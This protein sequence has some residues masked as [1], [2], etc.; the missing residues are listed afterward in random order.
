MSLHQQKIGFWMILLC[1]MTSTLHAEIVISDV[2]GSSDGCNGSFHLLVN[3]NAG[4]FTIEVESG[5]VLYPLPSGTPQPVTEFDGVI[6]DLCE[7]FYSVMVE[8]SKGCINYYYVDVEHCDFEFEFNIR[9]PTTC[10]SENGRI[11]VG[12]GSNGPTILEGATT[13]LHIEWSNGVV[14][15]GASGLTGISNLGPGEYSVTVTDATGCSDIGTISLYAEDGIELE[16]FYLAGSCEGD[17]NGIAEVIASSSGSPLDFTYN[18]T[19]SETG[20]IAESLWPGWSCVTVTDNVSDCEAVACIEIETIQP[21]PEPFAPSFTEVPYCYSDENPLGELIYHPQGGTPPFEWEWEW[22][23]PGIVGYLGSGSQNYLPEGIYNVTITDHCGEVFEDSYKIIKTNLDLNA[24]VVNE[25]SSDDPDE[26]TGSITL[27]PDA[28]P[29][30]FGPF[31]YE[32]YWPWQGSHPYEFPTDNSNELTGLFNDTGPNW[33]VTVTDGIGCTRV[34]N[35][36]I[37]VDDVE[38][39]VKKGHYDGTW[40][41]PIGGGN[42]GIL[43]ADACQLRQFCGSN[44]VEGGETSSTPLG[45]YRDQSGCWS[46]VNCE[47][48]GEELYPI[49]GTSSNSESVSFDG[50]TCL[51]VQICDFFTDVD[52]QFK[53]EDV[54]QEFPYEVIFRERNEIP[55]EP[56]YIYSEDEEN[57]GECTRTTFCFGEVVGEEDVSCGQ[58]SVDLDE[59]EQDTDNTLGE[60]NNLNEAY[61]HLYDG[62]CDVAYYCM[63]GDETIQVGWLDGPEVQ[64]C[65]WE[66]LDAEGEVYTHSIRSFCNCGPEPINDLNAVAVGKKT[67]FEEGAVWNSYY[68]PIIISEDN[69]PSCGELLHQQLCISARPNGNQSRNEIIENEIDNQNVL[70]LDGKSKIELKIETFRI[71]PNPFQDN[72]TIYA[73][74]IKETF[75]GEVMLINFLGQVVYEKRMTFDKDS[76]ITYVNGFENL[77]PGIYNLV[78]MKNNEMVMYEFLVKS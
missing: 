3:G 9:N 48:N 59:E 16:I 70:K 64:P 60:C 56:F 66:K 71:A 25:C 54:A 76:S 49:F 40:V 39:Y 68:G 18:W 72:F 42:I 8:N 44:E 6:S 37:N 47:F 36:D 32:W 63:V 55:G 30:N 1:F 12:S 7:G 61:E 15:E 73:D 29:T 57:P 26:N 10:G 77:I 17:N 21:N 28:I 75:Q 19:N 35:F 65:R 38:W 41:A 14:H 27:N 11:N 24:T 46:S 31:T 5:G 50:V 53:P 74:N 45:I 34:Q 43:Y 4:P 2:V 51:K 58:V 13:P 23:S 78:V 22:N 20:A 67:I 52:L 33:W 62:G 69:I